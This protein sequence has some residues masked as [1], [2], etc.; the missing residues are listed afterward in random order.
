MVQSRLRV[1]QLASGDLWAG[2]E[3]QLFALCGALMARPDIE[4][5][6]ILLNEGELADRLR[7]MGADLVVF[8]E[9]RLSPL[10]ILRQV[11]RVVQQWRPQVLHTHR[12]KENIVGGV[13]AALAGVPSVRTQH[14]APEQ[15]RSRVDVRRQLIH[16]LDVGVGRFVQRRVVAV[17]EDLRTKLLRDYPSRHVITI[18][19]GIAFE[20]LDAAEPVALGAART[21]GIVGRLTGV[22]RIDLFLHMAALLSARPALAD[23]Q[24]YVIGGGPL[25]ADLRALAQR[26][27]VAARVAFVG[28]VSP[29]AGWIKALDV[30][31]MCSDHEGMPMT[32]LE[33][34]RLRTA[35]VAHRVG[36]LVEL[37]QGDEAAGE[38]DCAQLVAEH[39]ASGYADA[40]ERVLGDAPATA[41]RVA[42]A[43]N[44][45]TRLYSASANAERFVALYRD[46]VAGG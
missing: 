23:V 12:F 13:A 36:G 40:V 27:G 15:A 33:A 45:V 38:G 2:A 10:A 6:V 14:G 1:L 31:V 30:L 3:V 34:M 37:L 26:L 17:T 18:A 43:F 22:K 35:I 28:H 8:D 29:A 5:R 46:I 44:R 25:E 41:M 20:P 42:N 7:A 16:L 19:N 32:L 9:R 39:T 11:L 24:F 4:L 21:V